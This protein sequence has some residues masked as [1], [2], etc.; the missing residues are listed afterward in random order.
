MQCES[1]TPT[2][3]K[4]VEIFKKFNPTVK[5]DNDPHIAMDPTFMFTVALHIGG[6][7]YCKF[8]LKTVRYDVRSQSF[9]LEYKNLA[10]IIPERRIRIMGSGNC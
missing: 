2:V 3:D 10:P 6:R 8:V 7:K 5:Y 4:L 1:V 9:E